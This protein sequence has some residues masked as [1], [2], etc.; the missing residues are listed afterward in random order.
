MKRKLKSLFVRIYRTITR[1]EMVLLPGQLAF[2]LVLAII[3]TV[4]LIAYGASL[5]NIS[6]DFLFD[7]FQK[8]FSKEIADL[9]LSTSNNVNQGMELTIILVICYYLSSNGS[10]AIIVTSNTIYGVKNNNWFRRRF[11]S[12]VMSVIFVLLIVFLLVVPILGNYIIDLI[13]KVNLN[14]TI[15]NAIVNGYHV[16][17]SPLMWVI[18]FLLIKIIYMLAPDR[19]IT[20]HNANYGAFF[21]TVSWIVV[22]TLYSYYINNIANYSS[23]YGGL[24]SVCALMVWFYFLAYTFVIGM[25][26]NYQKESDE[27]EYERTIK[28]DQTAS[29]V[30]ELLE[31]EAEESL[32]KSQNAKRLRKSKGTKK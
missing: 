30:R 3:P 19:Q 21:T 28:M 7:F 32:E 10:S 8:A 25:S 27:K 13:E 16:L 18:L 26:L 1:P 5:L 11:K 6:M 2:F 31:K 14:T 29:K 22:T 17:K 24:A 9:I 4:T 15:T 23:F 12:I 20:G